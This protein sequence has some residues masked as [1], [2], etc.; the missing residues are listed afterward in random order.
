ML[1]KRSSLS[2][3]ASTTPKN[4]PEYQ[5]GIHFPT[6]SHI[7]RVFIKYLRSFYR[8]GS[9]FQAHRGLTAESAWGSGMGARKQSILNEQVG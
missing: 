6:R 4:V 8:L 3:L 7:Q 2:Y 9:G 1:S 5:R